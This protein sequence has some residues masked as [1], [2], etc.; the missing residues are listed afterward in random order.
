MSYNYNFFKAGRLWQ[1]G[2]ETGADVA[3]LASL[4]RKL[5]TAL[6]APVASLRFDKRTLELLDTDKDGF[7]RQQEVL[8]AIDF[9]SKR[10][11]SLDALFAG[12][13]TE[14]LQLDL[15][16]KETPEGK[17]LA[18]LA[19]LIVENA[20]KKGAKEITL[21]EINA[22][23]ATFK[24]FADAQAFVDWAE[25]GKAVKTRIN[26]ENYPVFAAIEAKVDEFFPATAEGALVAE[27]PDAVLD[28]AA[29]L[30]PAYAAS[31]AKF[32]NESAKAVLGRDLGGKLSRADWE[33]AKAAFAPYK[34]WLAAK[35]EGVAGSV[36]DFKKDLASP[37]AKKSLS[38]S[39]Q[40]VRTGAA[41]LEKV[42]LFTK[43]LGEFLKN[44]VNQAKLYDGSNEAV[45]RVGTLYIDARECTLCF[46]VSDEG[47]HSALA[48]KSRCC[49]L[50]A[51]LVRGAATRTICAVVTAGD[52][53]DL[54]AGRNG[55]F[56]DRDGLD[57]AATVSKVVEAQI[58]LREAFW[59]PWKKIFNTVGEQLKKFIGSKGDA[60]TAAITEKV[61]TP[62]AAPSKADGAALASSVAALSVGIG[63]AG[64]ALAGLIGA[65]AGL[66]AKDVALGLLAM[67]LIV[68]LPSVILTW[69]NLRNRD[70]GAILNA[71]GWA[72][73]RPL[74]F[75]LKLARK[76]TL[77]SKPCCCKCI[78][79]AVLFAIAI[80]S[81]AALCY[82]HCH[83]C[84][85]PAA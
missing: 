20:G 45:Y 33:A 67:V 78:I 41:E 23:E 59:A 68:S 65:I 64:A 80:A 57:W 63:M 1:A 7:I 27:A 25:A 19:N 56:I 12:E 8:D 84:C 2:L 4:D 76:F 82:L 73:N 10:L 70:I 36:E 43:N 26:E 24:R 72:V 55:L 5:W 53:A 44:F 66:P 54:Y 21:A 11:S 74:R 62:P 35:P 30:N 15:L 32:V 81:I 28:L 9:L 34:A 85:A 16:N 50:Y 17:N 58:S 69:F 31:V 52:V 29:N 39:D 13:R 40:G 83:G 48:A 18:T 77:T 61:E 71:G 3:N 22:I 46:D 75:S 79:V 51:K 47:A 38:L 60:A 6:V 49:L 42:V 14:T 37:L